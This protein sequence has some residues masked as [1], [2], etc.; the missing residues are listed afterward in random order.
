VRYLTVN[1]AADVLGLSPV[2]IRSLAASGELQ[3]D[4]LGRDWIFSTQVIE[5]AAKRQRPGPGRPEAT[6]DDAT[7]KD[8]ILRAIGS[9]YGT[10][11]GLSAQFPSERAV[12]I[13]R[14]LDEL[15]DTGTLETQHQQG[16][17]QIWHV[18][19]IR[20][21]RIRMRDDLLR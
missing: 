20:G 1:E 14:M 19:P 11:A 5:R 4:K 10:V 9:R 16:L 7:L 12:R 13:R 8:R 6:V 17:G 21:V 18:A 3:A 2:R 15:T